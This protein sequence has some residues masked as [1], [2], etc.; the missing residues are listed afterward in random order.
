MIEFL[1]WLFFSYD[2]RR[3]Y[4]QPIFDIGSFEDCEFADK[5]AVEKRN[6]LVKQLTTIVDEVF[7]DFL[8]LPLM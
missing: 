5:T 4:G 3:R 2:E 6:L 1:C 7:I 8:D